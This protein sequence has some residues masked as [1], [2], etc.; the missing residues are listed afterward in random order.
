MPRFRWSLVI[1]ALL[2]VSVSPAQAQQ[3]WQVPANVDAGPLEADVRALLQLSGTFRSQCERIAVD[4]RVRVRLSIADNLDGPR[5]ETTFRRFP[6]GLLFADV[7]ILFGGSYREL[8]G[9]EFEH[10]IEQLDGLDLHHEAAEGRAWEVGGG[11]FETRRAY[12]AGVQ[13][14]REAAPPPR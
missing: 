5:A 3:S 2:L 9:H 6:S 14:L 11:A 10:V 7:A 13:V 1:P 12:R 8:L 4:P